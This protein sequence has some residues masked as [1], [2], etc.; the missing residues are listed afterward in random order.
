MG[1]ISA[2]K[3]QFRSVLQWDDPQEWEIF[4]QYKKR[5]DEIKNLSKLVL[6][7]GQGCIFTWLI[8][9]KSCKNP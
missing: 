7:P 3:N 8:S 4:R 9:D 1:L 5:N 6:Q 2:T